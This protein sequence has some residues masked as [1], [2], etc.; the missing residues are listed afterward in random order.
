MVRLFA[1]IGGVVHLC[2]CFFYLVKVASN[3]PEQ[4]NLFLMDNGIEPDADR[5]HKYML[6]FYFINTVFT[7]VGFGDIGATNTS[8]RAFVVVIMYIGTIIFG[9][10]LAE[11]DTAVS[12]MRRFARKRGHEMQV[13]LDFL[14]SKNTPIKLEQDIMEWANFEWTTLED[15]NTSR[16][17]LRMVPAAHLDNLKKHLHSDRLLSV[18]LFASIKST[19]K[20][21][22]L[23]DLWLMMLSQTFAASKVIIGPET[24][25]ST[26]YIIR[27]G[28]VR[29]ITVDPVKRKPKSLAL[30]MPGDSFGVYSLMGETNASREWD[31]DNASFVA[32]PTF[33]ECQTLTKQAFADLI[34]NEYEK[35]VGNDIKRELES[36]MVERSKWKDDENPGEIHV[37]NPFVPCT[38]V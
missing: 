36:H 16:E 30:L 21:Q 22:L 13:L 12:Y 8:E 6:A 4:V 35:D 14:R 29:V 10:L 17:A 31:V 7:T 38:L 15:V 34:D 28:T 5:L 32:G 11:V 3:E 33:V 24:I 2:S 37:H 20:E 9:L 23:I 1:M 18:S 25:N 27:S 19:Y 26:M